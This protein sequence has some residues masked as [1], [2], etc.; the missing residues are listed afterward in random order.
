[1]EKIFWAYLPILFGIWILIRSFLLSIK[2]RN[3]L[4]WILSLAIALLNVYS[5]VSLFNMIVSKAWPSFMPHIIM[6]ISFVLLMIQNIRNN[7]NNYHLLLGILT[8][9]TILSNFYISSFVINIGNYPIWWNA[10]FTI[11]LI[12]GILLIMKLINNKSRLNWKL[13]FINTSLVFL[14]FILYSLT[15]I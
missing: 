6:G 4:N 7:E 14:L 2:H 10:V 11:I 13:F 5:I 15:I 3:A 9:S 12:L 1:M 8:L